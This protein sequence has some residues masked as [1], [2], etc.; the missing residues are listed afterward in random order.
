MQ[1]RRHFNAVPHT[2]PQAAPRLNPWLAPLLPTQ[3]HEQDADIRSEEA[4]A[5]ALDG[6]AYV[7][8]VV[9]QK[10]QKILM[11]APYAWFS[12]AWCHVSP[13]AS[14]PPS[15]NTRAHTTAVLL[16]AL[17]AG[18]QQSRHA[19]PR[20]TY[21]SPLYPSSP[22]PPAPRC[23]N[24]HTPGLA[25]CDYL[26]QPRG[27]HCGAGGGGHGGGAASGGPAQGGHQARG[28]HV[29][30]VWWVRVRECGLGLNVCVGGGGV[31]LESTR[32]G[33]T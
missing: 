33:T 8:H 23:P 31:L 29:V 13:I 10:Q 9:S 20:N 24:P 6:V 27:G 5:R 18:S 22:A 32:E 28:C 11:Y 25:L 17:R 19:L 3:N 30:H 26:P 16:G 7:F 14:P 12:T 1:P 2:S 21:P 4:L 15:P